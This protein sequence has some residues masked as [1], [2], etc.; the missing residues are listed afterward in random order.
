M[1][2][3]NCSFFHHVLI[4]PILA[5]G[6]AAERSQEIL[7][8]GQ[9][10]TSKRE[11]TGETND[12]DDLELPLFDVHTMVVATDNFSDVNKL[13]QGG[14]GIVYKVNPVLINFWRIMSCSFELIG[15]ESS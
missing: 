5:R 11:F 4:C 6:G 13:G 1:S 8:S 3:L 10:I 12:V 9:I 14:F 7:L 15:A 2:K